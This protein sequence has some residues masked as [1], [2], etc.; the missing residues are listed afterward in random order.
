MTYR[1]KPTE[2][3][4]EECESIIKGTYHGVLSCSNENEPYAVPINHAYV[5]GKFYFHCGVGGKKI[6]FIQ[7]NSSVVYTIM[8]YYGTTED[9]IN[10]NNCHGKWESVIAYGN[11][12]YIE[13]EQEIQELLN[14]KFLPYYGKKETCDN[15][16]NPHGNESTSDGS[17]EDGSK[18]RVGTTSK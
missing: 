9:F 7:R 16:D 4:N 12:Q 3:N 15:P 18:K 17:K 11:A 8:K 6:D 13:E 2:R 1:I 10:S 14:N 5:D